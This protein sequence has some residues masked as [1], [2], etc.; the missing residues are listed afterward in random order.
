LLGADDKPLS[1]AAGAPFKGAMRQ[2]E[3]IQFYPGE[4]LKQSMQRKLFNGVCAGCH[5]SVSGRELD[6]AVDVDVLTSASLTLADDAPIVL[7]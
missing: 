5:G 2:R 3:E 1:F 7:R 4:H 6:I